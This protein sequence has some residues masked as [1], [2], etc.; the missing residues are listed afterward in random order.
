MY[1]NISIDIRL[2][3][4]AQGQDA[5]LDSCHEAEITPTTDHVKPLLA[6]HI[7]ELLATARSNTSRKHPRLLMAVTLTTSCISPAFVFSPHS[8][9]RMVGTKNLSMLIIHSAVTGSTRPYTGTRSTLLFCP[10]D[11]ASN[12]AN[13]AVHYGD[14]T[15]LIKVRSPSTQVQ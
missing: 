15:H 14:P 3:A 9:I 7:R 5:I 11:F 8:S 4:V 13:H 6:I 10:H 1:T 12:D 2:D